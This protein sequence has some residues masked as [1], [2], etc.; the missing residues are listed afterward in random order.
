MKAEEL[1]GL[2]LWRVFSG[3]APE[4]SSPMASDGRHVLC[5]MES[6][7]A[8]HLG[9]KGFGRNVKGDGRTLP[10]SVHEVLAALEGESTSV[11][12]VARFCPLLWKLIYQFASKLELSY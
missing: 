5:L 10:S 8:L 2:G 6:P 11:V 9:C 7:A 1:M 3:S 12:P 4:Q